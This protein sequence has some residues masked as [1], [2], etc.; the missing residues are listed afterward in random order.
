MGKYR[1]NYSITVA[2]KI[3]R[4]LPP[5]ESWVEAQVHFQDWEQRDRGF[6][7]KSHPE[8][9]KYIFV[10][11][12]IGRYPNKPP[13]WALDACAELYTRE[14]IARSS[15]ILPGQK[16]STRTKANY[17]HLLE[18]LAYNIVKSDWASFAPLMDDIG[19]EISWF[20]GSQKIIELKQ[21]IRDTVPK[22]VKGK[23][24]SKSEKHQRKYLSQLW[25]KEVELAKRVR[26]VRGFKLYQEREFKHGY[27][28]ARW[29]EDNT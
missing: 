25:T 22:K 6:N 23:N 24:L 26:L 28:P 18:E 2:N 5:P 12:A 19:A 17:D 7:A 16:R 21:A 27:K 3:N 8:L 10:A 1:E 13:Q 11:L 15:I 29:L 14:A 9:E 20:S 4:E